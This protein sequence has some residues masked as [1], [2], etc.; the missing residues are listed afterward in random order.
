MDLSLTTRR[1][2]PYFDLL[3]LLEVWI[4]CAY[5]GEL[6]HQ[7]GHAIDH[8]EP[9]SRGGPTVIANLAL[10]C[11][12]CNAAKGIRTADEFGHP[13]VADRARSIALICE[14]IFTG[15]PTDSLAPLDS[16][17]LDATHRI[18]RLATNT[19]IREGI[20]LPWTSL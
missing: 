11:P 8:I 16:W 18:H 3:V 17:L 19:I 2:I 10:A 5:C 12:P 4:H 14:R 20:R 1:G 13:H 6:V 15:E 7:G 9:L